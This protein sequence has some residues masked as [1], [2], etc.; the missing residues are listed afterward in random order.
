MKHFKENIN[1][2]GIEPF[3]ELQYDLSLACFPN[4]A[5]E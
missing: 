3:N 5:E 1:F 2:D 4:K